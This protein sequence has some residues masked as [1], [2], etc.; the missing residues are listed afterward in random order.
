MV[1]GQKVFDLGFF[2]S[3]SSQKELWCLCLTGYKAVSACSL[4]NISPWSGFNS[5]LWW[6]LVNSTFIWGKRDS[7]LGRKR[8]VFRNW[9]LSP[10]LPMAKSV[11]LV[12]TVMII[13]LPPDWKH[14]FSGS[15]TLVR[16]SHSDEAL[17]VPGS[18]LHGGPAGSSDS[19]SSV[20]VPTEV[21]LLTPFNFWSPTGPSTALCTWGRLNA[22]ERLLEKG[23]NTPAGAKAKEV[24]RKLK[25]L[26]KEASSDCFCQNKIFSGGKRMH[27]KKGN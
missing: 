18:S 25:R 16:E 19:V 20:P 6:V 4:P 15:D 1:W 26:L 7:W 14:G 22:E 23:L 24:S 13:F 27:F 2:T 11:H 3:N 9:S 5:T 8:M 12:S 17:M 10:L 21:G